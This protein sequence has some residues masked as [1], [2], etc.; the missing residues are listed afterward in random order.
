MSER[1]PTPEQRAAID[2]EGRIQG[3]LTATGAMPTFFDTLAARGVSLDPAL[4]QPS[5]GAA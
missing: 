5:G 1:K 3:A 4:F 2:A